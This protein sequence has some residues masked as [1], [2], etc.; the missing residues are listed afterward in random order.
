MGLASS[1]EAAEIAWLGETRASDPAVVGGKAAYLSQL[2]TEF[3]VPAGFCLT[4]VRLS[5]AY[6]SGY[7]A[8]LASAYEELA[9]RCGRTDPPVAV[10]SSAADE[11]GSGASFAGQHE[12]ILGVA[13]QEAVAAAVRDCLAS[14]GSA[15]ALTYR[16]QHGL[17]VTPPRWAVLVQRLVPA[18]AAGVAFSLDPV[19][20]NRGMVVIDANLGLGESV[21]SGTVTPD[22]YLVRSE[23]LAIVDRRCGDKRVMTVPVLGGVDEVTLPRALRSAP[24]LN[25]GQVRATARL[26]LDLERRMGW[27]VDVEF[28]W[29]DG[30]LYL[31]QCRPVTTS[32]TSKRSTT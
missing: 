30:R 25:D 14:F 5:Q 19:S 12:T 4:G 10:R 28:A 15:R 11:D 20:G 9:R 6:D 3:A 27:P 24:A 7:A 16:R 18:D 29:S 2:A 23:G 22:S 32:T 26:A 13:G 17:S 31:L 1:A 8:P 21:V